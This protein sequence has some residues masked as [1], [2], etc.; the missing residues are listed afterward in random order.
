MMRVVHLLGEKG[1]S[2]QVWTI[3]PTQPVIDAVRLM[4]EKH[5][6]ALPVMVNDEVIGIVTERDYARKVALYDRSSATTPV[7]DIMTDH[8]ITVRPEDTIQFCMHLMTEKRF[9]HLPVVDKGRLVGMVS[10][11]DLLKTVIDEQQQ[12]IAQLEKYITS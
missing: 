4:A 5:I 2:M 8:V 6:G 12:T 3:T 10:I 7:K 9:R 1:K 11:G